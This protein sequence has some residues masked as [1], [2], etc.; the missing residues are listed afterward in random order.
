MEPPLRD[1][2]KPLLFLPTGIGLGFRIDQGCTRKRG[3]VYSGD[4]S[5]DD[6]ILDTACVQIGD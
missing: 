3:G 1:E 4:G 2:I 6:Q 5:V